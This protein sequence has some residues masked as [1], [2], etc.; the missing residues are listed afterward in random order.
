MRGTTLRR[1]KAM[2]KSVVIAVWQRIQDAKKNA[3][4]A[5]DT[6]FVVR[7]R[8]DIEALTTVLALFLNQHEPRDESMSCPACSYC[9]FIRPWPCEIWQIAIRE[10]VDKI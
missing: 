2:Q 6:V 9:G 8:H 10:L 5:E 7:A 1:V 3:H 4:A